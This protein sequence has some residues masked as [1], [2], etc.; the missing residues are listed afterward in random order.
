MGSNRNNNNNTSNRV[1]KERKDNLSVTGHAPRI[2]SRSASNKSKKRVKLY[3]NSK[4]LVTPVNSMV[5]C[6]WDDT[7]F[8]T[9]WINKENIDLT[10]L[11]ARYRYARYFDALD[12][13][14]SSTIKRIKKHGDLMII[15]NATRQWVL[16]TLTVLP[17]TKKTLKDIP[18][19]SAR[20]S[21]QHHC[22]IQDWKK[23][24]FKAELSKKGRTHYKNII[25]IGDAHYEHRAL[26]SLYRW[27]V[28]PHKYLKSIKFTRSTDCIDLFNQ[29]RMIGTEI[30]NI[31]SAQR[32]LD[33]TL[34]I[35][36]HEQ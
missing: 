11:R 24:T 4:L 32:H 27:D 36:G 25:S 33:L 10:D 8:P 13:Y 17:K 16:I 26:V 15:T 5:I 28:I 18:I 23:Y 9:S 21:F 1:K 3:N 31:T 20:E 19:V 14:L 34:D 29:V 30:K 6:D 22:S 7:L 35:V 2:R 12:K